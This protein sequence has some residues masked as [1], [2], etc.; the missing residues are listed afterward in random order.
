MLQRRQRG[1]ALE[2]GH[3]ER[4][5]GRAVLVADADRPKERLATRIHRDEFPNSFPQQEQRGECSLILDAD[6][7][8]AE[9]ERGTE[10]I[11]EFGLQV[12]ERGRVQRPDL[13]GGSDAVGS[14]N[15]LSRVI[16]DEEV[17]IGFIEL[18]EVLLAF[19]FPRQPPGT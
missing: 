19:L 11:D 3:H 13:I 7:R 5:R 16:P 2:E 9:F 4:S 1:V 10:T 15:L 12:E 6:E 18:V 14:H 17:Q 8:A